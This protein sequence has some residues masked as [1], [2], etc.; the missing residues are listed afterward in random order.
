[1]KFRSDPRSL[2]GAFA[3]VATPFADDGSLDLE[4]LT[5]LARWQRE[6]GSHGLSVGGSTA[7][8]SSQTNDERIRAMQAVAAV[9]NDEIGFLPAVGTTKLDE[10]MELT[11]A[12]R[13]AGADAVLV[14]TPYYAKPTQAGLLDWYGAI[15][16]EF[17]ELPIVIYN[18][19]TR[20]AVDIHPAT[21][22]ELNKRHDNI[23][24]IKE[25]TKDFEHF[26]LVANATGREFM[27]WSGIELL[28]IPLLALGGAGFISALSNLAPGSLA[29]MYE[30]W[31]AGQLEEARSIHYRVHPL[32]DL[33]FVETNPAPAKWVLHRQGRIASPHVRPPLSPMSTAGEKRVLELMAEGEPTLRHEGLVAAPAA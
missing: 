9:T 12:A 23:I 4:S 17:P 27:I 19:P 18:V 33:L 16:T 2:R 5:S 7:E 14:I 30:L 8:P 28:C 26:S 10:T 32:V 22:A 1:M 21:V 20:T 25:T 3:A 29:E 6:A 31:E 11:A 13:D 24:G 15:A